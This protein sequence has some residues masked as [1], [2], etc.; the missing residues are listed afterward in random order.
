MNIALIKN[1][2]TG[3]TKIFGIGKAF[4][5]AYRPELLYGASV[6][7]TVGSVVLAAKGGYEAR[8][9]VE[10]AQN[11]TASLATPGTPLTIK[12]KALLTWTC[13]IPAAIGTVSAVGSTTG[14]HLVH[15]KEKKAMAAAGLAA[16]N[17]AREEMQAFKERAIE[18]MDDESKTPEEKKEAISD[19]LEGEDREW[20][21]EY[22]PTDGVYP[23]YD[24]LA[25]RAFRSNREL[26]RRAGEVLLSEINKHGRANLNLVYDELGM[27]E[28][29]IGQQLGWTKEEVQGYG[30]KNGMEFITF[31]LTELPDG[32]SATAFW[33]RE[34]PTTDY[35]VRATSAP[36]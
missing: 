28:S 33:F 27:S 19:Y 24:D 31:G 20:N 29:Q 15:V 3:G 17:Q 16:I 36:A 4:V 9:R 8:G 35:E 7:S 30:G 5:M 6:V 32:S 10:E 13:Y 11:A 22:V 12:E 34:P 23:C 26:I 14:L 21:T 2:S 18:L 25:N 1:I